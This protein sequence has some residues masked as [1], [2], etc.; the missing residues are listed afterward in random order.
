MVAVWPSRT[1]EV[2]GASS[3][4]NH[5]VI[6]LR[7]RLCLLRFKND[8]EEN[9]FCSCHVPFE[10]FAKPRPLFLVQNVDQGRATPGPLGL[11][12]SQ[13]SSHFHLTASQ[14]IFQVPVMIDVH[15]L[16]ALLP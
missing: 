6:Q 12:G 9:L 15:R 16:D 11:V 8:V 7:A 13:T 14:A 2:G 10:N 5:R 3:N 1:A 4:Q